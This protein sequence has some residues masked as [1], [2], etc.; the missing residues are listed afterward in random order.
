MYY[1]LYAW[2]GGGAGGGNNYLYLDIFELYVYSISII[3]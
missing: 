1:A 3:Q 2:G